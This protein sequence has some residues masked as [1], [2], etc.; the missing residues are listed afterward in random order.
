[1]WL[2]VS[3]L[4]AVIECN[5][6]VMYKGCLYSERKSCGSSPLT[7]SWAYE[8]PENLI[9]RQTFR[10]FSRRSYPKRLTISTFAMHLLA[11][12]LQSSLFKLPKTR[13]SLHIFNHDLNHIFQIAPYNCLICSWRKCFHYNQFYD[14]KQQCQTKARSSSSSDYPDQDVQ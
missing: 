9:L 8:W 14:H 10:A 4:S 6:N 13:I 2:T 7:T 12:M 3:R 1:M 5:M 11:W